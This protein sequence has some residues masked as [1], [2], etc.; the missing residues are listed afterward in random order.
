VA[1]G[2]LPATVDRCFA[3]LDWIKAEFGEDGEES[4]YG[5][6]ETVLTEA[7]NAKDTG[8]VDVKK[9]DR[10]LLKVDTPIIQTV[11]LASDPRSI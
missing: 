5:Q 4:D 9:K 6:G 2:E 3:D 10:S 11:F 1:R 8:C 7:L